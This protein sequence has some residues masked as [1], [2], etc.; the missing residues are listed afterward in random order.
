R[1][2][3]EDPLLDAIHLF[4][5]NCNSPD[6][7]TGRYINPIRTIK[8]D[9]ENS[10]G[11]LSIIGVVG[12]NSEYPPNDSYE[13]LLEWAKEHTPS[14]CYTILK[15]TKPCNSLIPYRRIFDDRKYV[16]LL[17]MT[18]AFRHARELGKI[19]DE[20][21]HK[22]EDISY[23]FNRP[24]STISEEY[25]IGSTT[26]DWKTPRLKL[27]TTDKTG[28][29]RTYQRGGDSNPTKDLEPRV[30]LMIKFLQCYNYWFIR[31]A[32]KSGSLSTYLVHVISQDCNPLILMKPTT[33]LKVCYMALI[34]QFCLSNN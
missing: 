22:L 25:W 16:E 31:C 9:D 33:L 27:I 20:H 5:N 28:E 14:E 10:L 11:V 2:K 29:I 13:D 34:H 7:N 19:F 24:A 18:H 23:I 4:G 17:G 6:K 8:T 32:A 26:N 21:S 15:S 1:F 30:P 3:T 12:V